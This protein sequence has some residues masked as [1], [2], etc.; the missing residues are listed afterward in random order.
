MYLRQSWCKGQKGASAWLSYPFTSHESVAERLSARLLGRA[1]DA[2]V[3]GK[4]DP[5][6][7]FDAGYYAETLRQITF[8]YRFDML[9]PAERSRWK[10]R[11]ETSALDGRPW[12]T[13]SGSV[14]FPRRT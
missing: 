9:S 4:T 10:L 6:V 13:N 14:N 1:A 2:A 8:V 12:P 5:M 11:G 3:A 7:W